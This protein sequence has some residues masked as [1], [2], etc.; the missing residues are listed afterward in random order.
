MIYY[1]VAC[2]A[3]VWLHSNSIDL[4]FIL[5]YRHKLL[6]YFNNSNNLYN[7]TL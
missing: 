4:N 6:K 3:I 1:C 7:F 2:I 5:I